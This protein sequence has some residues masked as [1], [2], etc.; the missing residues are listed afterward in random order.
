[1]KNDYLQKWALIAEIVGGF[2]VVLTLIFLILE[3]R[4][5][6]NAIK[7][8]TYQ[9]LTAELNEVRREITSL[10]VPL[11]MADSGGNG[12]EA[13]SRS[14]QSRVI[15]SFQALW[16]VYETAFYSFQRGT[17]GDDEWER[18]SLAICRTYFSSI[19]MWDREGPD[20]SR[21]ITPLFR[22]YVEGSCE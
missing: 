4:E 14:D 20:I 8:Q 3:T 16:S 7:A 13:L 10:N 1:M 5:N 6:T 11:I 15:I 22:D 19:G 2:A 18:Y 17:L 9:M 12:I 21:N